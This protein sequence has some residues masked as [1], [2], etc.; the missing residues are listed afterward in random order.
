[1]V[2]LFEMTPE[3]L[4]QKRTPLAGTIKCPDWSEL[5]GL[6]EGAAAPSELTEHLSVCARCQ[7]RL[8]GIAGGDDWW[9]RA[10]RSLTPVPRPP[11]RPDFHRFIEDLRETPK[12]APLP[13]GDP[14]EDRDWLLEF[15]A[16]TDR[17]ASLGRLGD[18]EISQI[19]GHGGMGIVLKAYDPALLRVVAIKV[20]APQLAT[21]AS[22]RKR[23]AREAQAAAA[24]RHEHV[25]A[26]HA[27][28]EVKGLPYLVMEYV[29]GVSLED[30]LASKEKLGLAEILRIGMQIASGLAAAHEQGLIH[31]DIKPANILLEN[32]MMCVKLTDFGLARTIDDA[33]LTRS[34]FLAGTP[35]YMAPE[36]ARGE[37]LDYRADLY[38][39]GSVLYALCTGRPPFA[40]QSTLVVVK[41]VSEEQPSSIRELRPDLPDWLANIIARLH[42]LQPADRFS[43]ASEVAD[44]LRQCLAHLQQ[45]ALVPLPRVPALRPPNRFT[46]RRT[47]IAL[48]RWFRHKGKTM[49]EFTARHLLWFV[50]GGIVLVA[51]IS[52]GLTSLRQRDTTVLK[53]IDSI[54]VGMS[55]AD[56][57]ALLDPAHPRKIATPQK[58]MLYEVYGD[59]EW[60]TIVLEQNG[61]ELRV[62]NIKREKDEGPTWERLRRKW[63]DRLR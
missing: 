56:V 47:A 44:L 46:S 27:V 58:G 20:L 22:A 14:R 40:A 43:C 26:I 1:L 41:R 12:E 25:V 52:A 7:K 38:S 62:A 19:L 53:A 39:L 54:Q 8:Q 63:E 24:I 9:Y 49:R 31:R 29:P 11:S 60:V 15:L 36:Q 45:P 28:A 5:Q 6:L 21:S 50:A 61:D 35:E 3:S 48:G 18:Y 4:L 23:F 51:L 10:T 55:E 16:P 59:D 17:E 34:G 32:G 30:R 13:E 57:Q 42:A 37:A 2:I 33:R